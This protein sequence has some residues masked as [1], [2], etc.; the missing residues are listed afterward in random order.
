[1]EK[2]IAAACRHPDGGV[3]SLP[4]PAR[5]GQVLRL[6]E[7]C[8]HFDDS[9]AAHKVEQGFVTDHFR[10]VN[11]VEARDLADKTGQTSPRDKK[12]PELYSEDLW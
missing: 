6:V 4:A 8:Y 1:M 10:F 3:Y 12:L 9:Q 11:R 7:A 2:I 5:H